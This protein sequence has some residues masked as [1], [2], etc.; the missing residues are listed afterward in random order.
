MSKRVRSSSSSKKSVAKKIVKIE[1]P[2]DCES[3][4]KRFQSI[5]DPSKKAEFKKECEKLIDS[6]WYNDSDKDHITIFGKNLT[7]PVEDGLED[8]PD[9]FGA[10]YLDMNACKLHFFAYGKDDHLISIWDK[11]PEAAKIYAK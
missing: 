5:S 8:I 3:L 11:K 6:L 4:C 7:G 10:G 2:R 1:L 9:C